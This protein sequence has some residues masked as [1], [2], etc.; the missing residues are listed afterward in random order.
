MYLFN[1]LKFNHS[2]QQTIGNTQ[3]P[4]GWFNDSLE[5]AKVGVIEVPDPIRPDDNL[6]ISTENPD[7]SYTAVPRTATD[8]ITRHATAKTTF[9]AQVKYEVGELIQQ[10][11]SGLASEYELAEKEATEYKAA[12]YPATRIPGSVQSEINSK[13]AK[14]VS[15]TAAAATDAILAAAESWRITQAVIRDTRLTTVSAAEVTTDI[16]MLNTIKVQ[17]SRFM[18]SSRDQLGLQSLFVGL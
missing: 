8:L 15:I 18:A 14:G 5:R 9:I 4:P 6:F 1:N 10:A 11:L 2:V 17:W 16:D 13:A 7:G 3:Y 12:G